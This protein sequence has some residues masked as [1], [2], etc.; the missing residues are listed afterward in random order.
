MAAGEA[1]ALIEAGIKSGVLG[2]DEIFRRLIAGVL[3]AA[4]YDLFY[5]SVVN[6]NTGSKFHIFSLFRSRFYY[7]YA[8]EI[9]KV[10]YSAVSVEPGQF[11]RT[12]PEYKADR[13]QHRYGRNEK[14][15]PDS[16]GPKQN[17]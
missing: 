11:G 9:K 16:Y 4:A 14:G 15:S 3:Q 1:A 7:Y 5:F 13:R 12:E 6:I 10:K 2:G 8:R 17:M